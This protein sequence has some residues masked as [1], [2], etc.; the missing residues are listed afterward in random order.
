MMLCGVGER[1]GRK[2]GE[3]SLTRAG[4]GGE[5]LTKAAEAGWGRQ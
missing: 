5:A 3:P 1:K 2:E 4:A